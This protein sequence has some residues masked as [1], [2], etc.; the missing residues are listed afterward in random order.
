MYIVFGVK[1]FGKITHAEIAM[2]DLVLFVGNNNSGKTMLM[3]LIYGTMEYFYKNQIVHTEEIEE[4]ENSSYV[5]DTQW[6]SEL[7]KK[8]NDVLKKNK[9]K[10]VEDI[11][12]KNIQIEELYIKIENIEGKYIAEYKRID[13]SHTN[14]EYQEDDEIIIT[15]E[16]ICRYDLWY[17]IKKEKDTKR[18]LIVSVR[19]FTQSPK[20]IIN[21]LSG[22][23]QNAI[24]LGG[25][26]VS[27]KQ[28]FLPASRTGI[29]LLYKYFFSGRDK[30][31]IN[32]IQ[33]END[34]Y[35]DNIYGLT[36]P[37]YEYLQF[38]QNYT[39]DTKTENSNRDLLQ[40]MEQ[41]ML[42]GKI[43]QESE[44]IYYQEFNT[45]ERVPLYLAS[46]M[47]NEM[48]PVVKAL[49]S[50]NRFNT[51]YW[52]EIETCIHPLKQGELARFIVRAVNNG[53]RMII[54]THS[55]TMACKLNNLIV[56]SAI[57]NDEKRDTKLKK[58]K[59][60]SDDIL[61]NRSVSVYQFTNHENGKSNVKELHFKSAPQVGY[62]FKLFMQS[63]EEL[64]KETEILME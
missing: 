15:S 17:E 49:T 52:D 20:G 53:N 45:E 40:F 7:E 13:N 12:K 37:V 35:N 25:R 59:L 6:F 10:I 34:L 33:F 9:E 29:Q 56:L 14:K 26:T 57:E 4:I 11:F 50:V 39:K 44:D 46:A 22:I 42:D 63:L 28:L 21:T 16:E 51:Y 48:T 61:E 3:Q 23:V 43:T 31:L 8:W 62:D 24:L 19:F 32:E 30:H 5:F 18:E 60:E 64:Y 2:K 27:L 58:M 38:L 41:H 54:S 36:T 55:D 1:N 47:I